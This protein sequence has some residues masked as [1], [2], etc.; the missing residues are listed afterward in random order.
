MSL[1]YHETWGINPNRR[2]KITINAMNRS[3][4]TMTADDKTEIV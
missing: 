4:I 3:G 2:T 1:L